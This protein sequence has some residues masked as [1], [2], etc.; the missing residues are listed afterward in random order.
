V[1]P[2]WLE[3]NQER[4]DDL[5]RQHKFAGWALTSAKENTGIENM[6]HLLIARVLANRERLQPKYDANAFKLQD[7]YGFIDE[8][9]ELEPP[10]SSRCKCIIS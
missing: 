6:I 4:M 2:T 8:S 3:L 5:V 1:V 10:I 7:C 9:D